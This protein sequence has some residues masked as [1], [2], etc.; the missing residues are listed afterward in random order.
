MMT[1]V[2]DA[3]SHYDEYK[4][5]EVQV[6]RNYDTDCAKRNYDSFDLLK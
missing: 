2:Q 4:Y 6:S 3:N 5:Y 1:W